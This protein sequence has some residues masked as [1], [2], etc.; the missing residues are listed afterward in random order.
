MLRRGSETLAKPRQPDEEQEG[1][2]WCLSALTA[3]E[4]EIPEVAISKGCR[5]SVRRRIQFAIDIQYCS[6]ILME[7][8]KVT[9]GKYNKG[10][11]TNSCNDTCKCTYI[12][13]HLSQY[14]TYN[15]RTV[16][17]GYSNL[18]DETLDSNNKENSKNWYG[19]TFYPVG[20]EW[21]SG[22]HVDDSIV[23]KNL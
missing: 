9:L 2:S 5:H 8:R 6:F 23:R 20:I 7:N 16:L 1:D 4:N 22:R 10:Q 15:I 3:G 13:R 11:L 17:C 14:V 19:V 21:D 18:K 12:A